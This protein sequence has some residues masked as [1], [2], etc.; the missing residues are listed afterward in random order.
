MNDNRVLYLLRH[1]K[2]SW[3]DPSLPDH[4]RPL[5]VRGRRDAGLIHEYLGASQ[6]QPG[7]IWCSS[8]LRTQQTLMAIYPEAQSDQDWLYSAGAEQIIERLRQVGPEV[9]SLMVIGHN[10]S[11]Q[12]L[13]LRLCQPGG[14]DAQIAAIREKL[15]TG[16]L[17]TLGF[18]GVWE[19]LGNGRLNL[20]DYVRPKL[21]RFKGDPKPGS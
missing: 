18:S 10:P 8:A 5:S 6:I 9:T 14:G 15:P 2:S 20:T 4:R 17:I 13:A 21:L 12:S 7:L 11:L 1:A 3:D 19:D 16:A